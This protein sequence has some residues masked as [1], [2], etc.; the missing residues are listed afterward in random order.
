M[1]HIKLE[2]MYKAEDFGQYTAP[3]P[4][5]INIPLTEAVNYITPEIIAKFHPN[6][7]LQKL[8]G[9]NAYVDA[10]SLQVLIFAE[11]G[12]FSIF[13]Y[14]NSSPKLN[15]IKVYNIREFCRINGFEVN[16]IDIEYS[17]AMIVKSTVKELYFAIEKNNLN[18]PY[19]R[20]YN[21]SLELHDS[22][23]ERVRIFAET[24]HIEIQKSYIGS[25][26]ISKTNED[27]HIWQSSDIGRLFLSERIEKFKLS[28]SNIKAVYASSKTRIEKFELSSSRIESLPRFEAEYVIDKNENTLNLIKTSYKEQGN[29]NKFSEFAYKLEE[30]KTDREENFLLKG[31]A[32]LLKWTCG[33]GYKP[34]RTIFASSFIIL[35]FG[36]I[37]SLPKAWDLKEY[38]IARLDS[39][40]ICFPENLIYGVLFSAESFLGFSSTQVKPM[41]L[42]MSILVALEALCG[43]LFFSLLIY[44][45][46]KRFSE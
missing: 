39:K 18:D 23:I 33:Y 27:L 17:K 15:H 37:F 6:I 31:L 45:L 13:R 2:L 34:L 42:G 22:N 38:N 12:Y 4:S 28:D 3:D 5:V 21:Q 1:D 16:R 24:K 26:E 7:D 36:I 9:F 8:Y 10:N 30:L 41:S 11:F 43:L 19:G 40:L 32:L 44:S 25:I 20:Q 46:T 35:A 29:Y 14:M